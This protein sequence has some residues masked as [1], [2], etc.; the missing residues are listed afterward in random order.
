MY[1]IIYLS[2]SSVTLFSFSFGVSLFS[3]GMMMTNDERRSNRKAEMNAAN[4]KLSK[5]SFRNTIIA[6]W[7]KV[8]LLAM[9]GIS[10]L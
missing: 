7:I 8:D 3:F 2:S 10:I 4:A 6:T 9:D 1:I 5:E